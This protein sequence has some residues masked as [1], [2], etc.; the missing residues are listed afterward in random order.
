GSLWHA[1]YASNRRFV[2]LDLDAPRGREA[3]AA[4]CARADV[5]LDAG[6]LARA[7]VD[8]A[9]LLRDHPR[10]VLVGV[11]SFGR[12]GPWRDHLAPDLVASALGGICATCGDVDTPPLKGFGEVAFAVSGAY[13]AIAALAALRHARE[14]GEGQRVDLSVHEAI[15]SCLEHVL[16]WLWYHDRLPMARGP[17]LARRGSLHWSDAYQVMAARDGAIMITPTPDAQR[18]IAWLAAEGAQQDVLDERYATAAVDPLVRTQLTHRL[19]QVL[20]EWVATKEVEPFFFE[21]QR[22]HHPFGWVLPP[23]RVAENPQLAARDWWV[24][25]P[26][27]DLADAG[28]RAPGAPYHLSETPWRAPGAHAAPDADTEAVLREIGWDA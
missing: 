4:L 3:L 10:L 17:A 12:E 7:G 19:M 14:T 16:M 6:T 13:A 2:A 21:A 5:V 25:L 18:L 9:A 11:S 22:R 27:G 28:A 20:R 24:P 1:F 23:D 26:P 15:A 8:G